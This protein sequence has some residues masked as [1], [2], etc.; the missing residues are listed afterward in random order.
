MR[1]SGLLEQNFLGTM[2]GANSLSTPSNIEAMTSMIHSN[3]KQR[4]PFDL[5]CSISTESIQDYLK[6]FSFEMFKICPKKKTTRPPPLKT[7]THT[8][9]QQFGLKKHGHYAMIIKTCTKLFHDDGMVTMFLGMV[10]MIHGI[11]IMFSM[12]SGSFVK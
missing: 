4:N 5:F 8:H 1:L 9:Q 3:F 2:I 12:F 11:I 7:H 10:G 6:L